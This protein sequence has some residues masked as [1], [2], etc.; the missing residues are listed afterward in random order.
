LP[1]FWPRG[2][3]RV[4]GFFCSKNSIDFRFAFR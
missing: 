2:A 1:H 3:M 4:R